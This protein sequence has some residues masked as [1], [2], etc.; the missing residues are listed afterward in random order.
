MVWNEL[1]K[2]V[3]PYKGYLMPFLTFF[4]IFELFQT[5]KQP[6]VRPNLEDREI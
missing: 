3:L 2:L 4:L 6:S 5:Y 1:L